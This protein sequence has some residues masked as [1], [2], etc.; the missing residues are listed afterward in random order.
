MREELSEL[1]RLKMENIAL[2]YRA[3]E[4]QMVGL[5]N[6]RALVIQQIE[7]DHPGYKWKEPVG[8]VSVSE[9]EE[10]EAVEYE[11]RPT[12]VR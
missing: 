8:L 3:M 5:L 4:Q 1:E 9:L 7:K 2:K 11:A 10:V 6:E 12:E